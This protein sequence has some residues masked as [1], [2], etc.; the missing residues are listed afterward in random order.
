MTALPAGRALALVT[1]ACL[2]IL[3]ATCKKQEPAAPAVAAGS[4]G[5]APTSPASARRVPVEVREAGYVPD[6][7]PGKPGE[8]L[9][10][11]L[12][13]KVDGHCY[14]ELKTPDG[15]LVALPKDRPVDVPITVPTEGE[16]KFTCGMD[17]LS[18]VVV[19]EPS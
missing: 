13:R 10:L 8:R 12:T 18:G 16:V 3:G 17:M 19:A 7:I 9:I 14:E 2:A 6:R 4:A 11:E 15:K 1:A 5:A